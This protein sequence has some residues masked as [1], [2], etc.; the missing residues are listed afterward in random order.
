MDIQELANKWTVNP[1]KLK[2]DYDELKEK[3]ETFTKL[4]AD[5]FM[6]MN[7]GLIKLQNER[8]EA[9][10]EVDRLRERDNASCDVIGQFMLERDEAR[11]SLRNA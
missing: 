2:Q 5:K 3:Y 6:D 4:M 9:R 7:R 11:A 1:D 8:D 10:E